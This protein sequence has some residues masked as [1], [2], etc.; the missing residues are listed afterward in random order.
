M[1]RYTDASGNV[2]VVQGINRVPEKYRASARTV[3]GS[4]LSTYGSPADAPET[5]SVPDAGAGEEEPLPSSGEWNAL[6][7]DWVPYEKGFKQAR[8]RQKPLF[9]L[10]YT[11]WCSVCKK[12]QQLFHDPGIIALAKGFV[13]VKADADRIE[14]VDIRFAPDGRYIPRVLFFSPSG[15]HYEKIN[16]GNEN[17]YYWG[18]EQVD[19]LKW[20]METTLYNFRAGVEP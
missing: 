9:L 12:S 17:R 4:K 10:I 16:M 5:E 6:Q 2:H 7:I 8:E 11:D 1:I 20:G 14:E 15:K 3:D 18:S 19:Q 13:M